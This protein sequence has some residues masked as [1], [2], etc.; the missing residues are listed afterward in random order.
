[1]VGG[2]ITNL[3][4]GVFGAA[5]F[6][7]VDFSTDTR[8]T[9]GTDPAC[10]A[11]TAYCGNKANAF[12]TN[13]QLGV[14]GGSMNVYAVAAPV[15]EPETYAMVLLGLGIVGLGTRRQRSNQRHGVPRDAA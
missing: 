13:N 1:M 9:T 12:A 15:P 3:R 4:G 10:P 7:F 6:P 5:D 14:F 2:Q 11:Q 8:V